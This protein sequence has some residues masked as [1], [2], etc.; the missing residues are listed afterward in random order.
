MRTIVN[1]FDDSS[2]LVSLDE[3][4]EFSR[5]TDSYDEVVVTMCLDAAH[6][7]IERWCNRK[8]YL[9]NMSGVTDEYKHKVLLPYPPVKT[10][11]SVTAENAEHE[12]VTLVEGVDY[13]FN[14]I[15]QCVTFISKQNTIKTYTDFTFNFDCGYDG[16]ENVPRSIKHAVLMTFATLYENREDNVVGASVASVPL[17]ARTVLAAV[18]VRSHP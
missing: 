10:L 7:L 11:N 2:Q 8:I 3:A 13:K 18:R 4:M 12:T 9:T 6:D 5:I 15:T 1:S 14:S 16:I 17:K